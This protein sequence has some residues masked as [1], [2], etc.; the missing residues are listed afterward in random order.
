MGLDGKRGLGEA[1]MV[2]GAAALYCYHKS[3]HDRHLLQSILTGVFRERRPKAQGTEKKKEED[4][5]IFQ[6]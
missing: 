1:V 3:L 5:I 2:G 6:P 4:H